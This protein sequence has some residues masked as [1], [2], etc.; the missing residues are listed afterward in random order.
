MPRAEVDGRSLHYE[1]HGS[2]APLVLIPGMGGDTRLF[3]PMARDLSASHRVLVFDHRDA[4]RSDVA[5]AEYGLD[6]LARDAAA[7]MAHVGMARATVLGYSMGG[8]VA[9]I[10]ALQRPDLVARLVLAATAARNEPARPGTWRWFLMNVAPRV[11][12]PRF[13]D[14]QSN[15]SFARQ[16]RATLG[17]DLTSRL[18]ELDVPTLVLHGERDHVVAPRLAEELASGIRGARLVVVP[19]GHMSKLWR[20]RG[21]LLTEVVAFSG[22]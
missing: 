5:S 3:G 10:L 21:R 4:G 14:P 9:I 17:C 2:G 20:E 1:V 16:R 13:V 15:R 22:H 12:L 6:D 7:L 11:P 19:G 8:R 18:G